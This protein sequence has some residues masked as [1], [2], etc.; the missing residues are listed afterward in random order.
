VQRRNGQREVPIEEV[1]PRDIVGLSPATWYPPTF[2][3][4]AP[5]HRHVRRF[6]DRVERRTA[7]HRGGASVTGLLTRLMFAAL[8]AAVSA[9]ALM[10]YGGVSLWR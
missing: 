9:S 8:V 3:G 10:G 1:I 5:V 7:F 2:P 6:G 4:A